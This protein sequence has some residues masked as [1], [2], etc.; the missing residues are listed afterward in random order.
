MSETDYFSLGL[1][2]TATVLHSS[3]LPQG[4]TKEQAIKLLLHDHEFFLRCD[5]HLVK[6][7]SIEPEKDQTSTL[8]ETL[9]K[10]DEMKCY[11]VTDLVH[12]LPAGLWDSNVVST[13]E[14]TNIADGLFVRIK[15][16][17]SVVM[18][19]IWTIRAGEAEGSVE[20]VEDVSI[21][22]SKLLVGTV[23]GLCESGW[24]KIHAKMIERLDTEVT[25]Q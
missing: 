7:E 21:N 3:K 17:M 10:T 9:Q 13:Y 1:N 18:D 8:P 22:C 4:T 25:K 20:L 19:T 2:G 16:P 15:S 12:T 24:S 5:P 23:K 14:M 11:K 6:F